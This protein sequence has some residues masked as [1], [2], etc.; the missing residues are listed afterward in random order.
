MSW[1]AGHPSTQHLPHVELQHAV[2][3]QIG[4]DPQQVEDLLP[5]I[6]SDF[7][8]TELPF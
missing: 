7:H 2:Y 1:S 5:K 3:D 6:E 8:C 4:I